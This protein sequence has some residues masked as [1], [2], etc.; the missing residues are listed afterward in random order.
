MNDSE[1]LEFLVPDFDRACDLL[2]LEFP[3]EMDFAKPFITGVLIACAFAYAPRS[4]MESAL[5]VI[6]HHCE[7]I[8]AG[9]YADAEDNG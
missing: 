7:M 5:Q 1:K 3:T 4:D 8:R 6:R 9:G 2:K